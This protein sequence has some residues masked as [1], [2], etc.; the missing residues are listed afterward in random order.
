[1]REHSN[2]ADEKLQEIGLG[3]ER[4]EGE[5]T[6]RYLRRLEESGKYLFHG[7]EQHILE[8][9]PRNPETD[10]TD[11]AENK[12][13]AVYAYDAAALA[14]QR[15]IAHRSGVEDWEI[16]GGTDPKHP[17]TPLLITSQNIPIGSGYLHVL[18]RDH[19]RHTVG[20]QWVSESAVRPLNV[21]DV[22]PSVY[23]ELG[24][25]HRYTNETE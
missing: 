17:E 13:L 14:V 6:A 2:H 5:S 23:A 7:S 9:E 3:I 16:I 12:L 15:A 1:M 22:D 19:F 24:G 11:E 25:V 20:Y 21:I 4:R 8:L 10:A 18:S